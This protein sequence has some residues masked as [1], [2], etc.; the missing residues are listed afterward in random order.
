MLHGKWKLLLLG[1]LA[2]G[3]GAIAHRIQG[4]VGLTAAGVGIGFGFLLCLLGHLALLRVQ[5]AGPRLLA[6]SVFIGVATSFLL[7]GGFVFT[8]AYLRREWL[9]TATLTALVLYTTYRLAEAFEVSRIVRKG[10]GPDGRQDE[11]RDGGP[12]ANESTEPPK[13]EF[14]SV[15]NVSNGAAY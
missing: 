6:A 15:V 7:M 3:S 8:L 12:P 1:V 14:S 10:I 9:V 2:L 13:T 11:G 5:K 4:P